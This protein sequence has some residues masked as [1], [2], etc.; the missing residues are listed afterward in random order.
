MREVVDLRVLGVDSVSDGTLTLTNTHEELLQGQR[1]LSG[2][3]TGDIRLRQPW[4][5]PYI[6]AIEKAEDATN[7]TEEVV[8]GDVAGTP[9][10]GVHN[11]TLES[12]VGWPRD[13]LEST[14]GPSNVLAPEDDLDLCGQLYTGWFDSSGLYAKNEVMDHLCWESNAYCVTDY[15]DGYDQRWW[16]PVGWSEVSHS[17]P[18]EEQSACEAEIWT[19]DEFSDS[20]TTTGYDPNGYVVHPGYS[21]YVVDPWKDDPCNTGIYW[22]LWGGP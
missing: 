7:C 4:H 12:R 2:G 20:C 17:G 13:E 16:W 14:A 8:V 6:G 18:Y 21:T 3:C 5:G 22:K 19:D 10:G 11:A 1:G 9:S 15:W